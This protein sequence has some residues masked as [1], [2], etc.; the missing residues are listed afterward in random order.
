M[1]LNA[2]K[3]LVTYRSFNDN[4]ALDTIEVFIANGINRVRFLNDLVAN[5]IFGIVEIEPDDI[6]AVGH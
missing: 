6:A 1:V 2:V 5:G 3:S 4:V